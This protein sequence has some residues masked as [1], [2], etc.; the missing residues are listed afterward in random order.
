MII[1]ELIKKLLEIPDQEEDIEIDE[2]ENIMQEW[3]EKEA[4]KLYEL[5][6]N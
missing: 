6:N 1:K 3:E 4:K 2:L 5:E